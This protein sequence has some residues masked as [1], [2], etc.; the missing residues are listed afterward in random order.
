MGR[1]G[2]VSISRFA[3]RKDKKKVGESQEDSQAELERKSKKDAR[4]R[5]YAFL[6]YPDSAPED[7]IARLDALHIEA[8]ISPLHDR[9]I[10]PEGGIKKPHWHVMLMFDGKKSLAQIDEIRDKVLGS[11]Y[12]RK[13]EDI[14][15]M[16][17]YARY[18]CHLD[19][20]EKAQYSRNDVVSLCGADYE[21]A[22]FLPGDDVKMMADIFSY[23][24][25]SGIYY[26]DQLMTAIKSSNPDWFSFL[27]QRRSYVVVQY[28]KARAARDR[29]G[30]P[31]VTSIS[32]CGVVSDED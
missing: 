7:W 15:S 9:D 2:I 10:D 19:N 16:R 5:Q 1:A 31:L 24:N 25:S 22:I 27:V 12:N 4:R 3:M 18:M 17:G 23:I 13:L 21:A 11:N 30:V 28:L 14:G 8:L 26:F 6:V 29:V 32:D 20:P